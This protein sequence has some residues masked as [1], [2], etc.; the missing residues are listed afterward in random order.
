M[1]AEESS[2]TVL[3][4]AIKAKSKKEVFRILTTEGE[5]YLPP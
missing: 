1:E 5:L 2:I 3:D 4:I